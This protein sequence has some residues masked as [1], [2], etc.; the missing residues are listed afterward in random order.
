MSLVRP[1]EPLHQLAFKK[2]VA[3]AS[4]QEITHNWEIFLFQVK[5]FWFRGLKK[6]PSIRSTKIIII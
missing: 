2:A 3:E 1:A 5:C 4:M 6:A